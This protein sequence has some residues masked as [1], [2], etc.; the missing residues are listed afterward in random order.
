[1]DDGRW[2]GSEEE[3]AMRASRDGIDVAAAIE[4]DSGDG[5]DQQAP[6]SGAGGRQRQRCVNR[7]R[8]VAGGNTSDNAAWGG[9]QNFYSTGGWLSIFESRDG[10]GVKK[11]LL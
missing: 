3:D 7:Q 8:L 10:S 6:G 4:L 5:T 1:M 11:L 9:G 2:R